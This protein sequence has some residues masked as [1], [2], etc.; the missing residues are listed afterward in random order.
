MLFR[1]CRVI[2]PWEDHADGWVRIHGDEIAAEGHFQPPDTLEGETVV[3]LQG[4]VLVPGFVDIH[5]HGCGGGRATDADGLAKMAAFQARHGCTA[6]VPTAQSLEPGW[7]GLVEQAR[8]SPLEGARVLGAHVEGAYVN[9]ACLGGLRPDLA[10]RT[11]AEG[12]LDPLLDAWGETIALMT[13]SPEIP[14]GMELIRALVARDV[15]ASV[16]HSCVTWDQFQEAVAAGLAHATH[17]FNA[18]RYGYPPPERGLSR[19]R[20]DEMVMLCD[21]VTTE[22]ICDGVHVH[23]IM[24]RLALKAKGLDLISLITDANWTAGLPQ[25]RYTLEDGQEVDV[26]PDDVV[27]SVGD[28]RIFGSN[29][30]MDRA[31]ANAVRLMDIPLR[32]AVQMA[33]I[34]PAHVVGVASRM[35]SLEVGKQANLVAFDPEVRVRLTCVDGIV[36]YDPDQRCPPCIHRR[37]LAG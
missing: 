30:S 10:R 35:G 7:L 22:V 17:L 15:V 28:G 13:L 21:E 29:L 14:G 23:P 37:V 36:V 25:G 11:F 6:F 24:L 20:L 4:L 5:C 9:P 8:R 31:V 19:A 12:E 33:T 2:T 26:R 32:E 34:N 27:R 3:D 18:T 1:N 16:G